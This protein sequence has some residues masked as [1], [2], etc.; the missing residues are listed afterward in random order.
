MRYKSVGLLNDVSSGAYDQTKTM[1]RGNVHS[2]T[3]SG[4]TYL[5]PSLNKWIDVFT[6]AGFS[7]IGTVVTSNGR[8]FS[9]SSEN[10]GIMSISLHTFNFVTGAS[11]YVGKINIR[12]ADVAATTTTL[13][14]FK[15]LDNAGTTGW[16]IFVCTT[17]SVLI[18][19]GLYTVNK[20]DL[21]DFTFLG[22]DFLF[23]TSSD[24]KAT[25]FS[26]D[27]ANVGVNQLMTSANGM[28]LDT[29][30]T[31][32]YIRNGTAAVYQ[33][34]VHDVSIAPVY[35]PTAVSVSVASPGVVN[36]VGH[37]FNNNDP[38]VFTA[39]TLPT[40][41]TVGTTYFVRNPVVDNY[42]LS[43][44]SGG[45]N[46]NTTG[47]ASVGAFIGRAFGTSTASFSHKTGNLPALSGTLIQNDSD[48][49]AMP[50][51]TTNAG[52]GCA[53]FTT[54]TN[55]YMG[56]LSELTS[57]T[58]AWPSLIFFNNNSGAGDIAQT[59]R[60]ASWS[61][62]LDK[63]ILNTTGS[64]RFILKPMQNTFSDRVF[65]R[66]NITQL[67][68][69]TP[70]VLYIGANTETNIVAMDFEG[71]WLFLTSSATGQ[72]GVIALDVRSDS[73]FGYSYIITPVVDIGISTLKAISRVRALDNQTDG[74]NIYY[75]TS[76]FGSETGGW[77]ALTAFALYNIPVSTQIQ[78]KVEYDTLTKEAK[79]LHAQLQD[80]TLLY[81]NINT[82]SENWQVS[83]DLS[84]TG[85]THKVVFY[86]ATAYASAVP[87]LYM[88]AFQQGTSNLVGSNN[89]LANPGQFRYS[90][91]GG[92][93]WN[94]L[95]T[96]PNVVGTLVEWTINPS[97]TVDYLPS[98]K[99]S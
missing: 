48:D 57:G 47:S 31:K 87:T 39:G 60:A 7:P 4:G 35:V 90:T 58:T 12:V 75:R 14:G 93:S 82:N 43:T 10:L 21:S 8:I 36:H 16:K 78:L 83:K 51:H 59:S 77:T 2:K 68:G 15:V 56:R 65:G 29:T 86:L 76:G 34:Y 91:N 30:N 98:V 54:S 37:T 84:S 17:G 81:E 19:G 99:E 9:I 49:Y 74:L 20:V 69:T 89:T 46:I 92:T 63:A 55:M 38:V 88:R 70:Q 40:G 85:A 25:Y 66:T 50:N 33:Y 62:I 42:N 18:N 27:P 6:D 52:F 67:E 94:A 44:T 79:G 23:G 41:L 13:R 71:G 22:T 11:S 1:I 73:L 28:V 96:I 53:F 5:G 64:I 24:A 26:Q 61:N 32:L 95:G 3:I 72:R 80:L 97:P 45:A